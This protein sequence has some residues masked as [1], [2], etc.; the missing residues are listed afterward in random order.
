ME[1]KIEGKWLQ[2]Y[3]NK[4]AAISRLPPPIPLPLEIS[5]LCE[6]CTSYLIIY[7]SKTKA[8]IQAEISYQYKVCYQYIH[9]QQ[10]YYITKFILSTKCLKHIKVLCTSGGVISML[11][12]FYLYY[13]HNKYCE[14]GMYSLFALCE[15]ALI[16]FCLLFH[17]TLFYDFHSRVLTLSSVLPSNL[18]QYELLSGDYNGKRT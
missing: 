3:T 5:L 13:R 7:N 11:L 4:Y 1:E 16:T 2:I 12:A 10:S 14:P 8:Q 9:G 17:C 15:Y 18:H 6:C